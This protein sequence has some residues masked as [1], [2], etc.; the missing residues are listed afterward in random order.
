MMSRSRMV[1]A[2]TAFGE[3]P[4]EAAL[5]LYGLLVRRQPDAGCRPVA[6]LSP[7]DSAVLAGLRRDAE[8]HGYADVVAFLAPPRLTEEAA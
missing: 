2:A 4:P 3:A 6:G 1:E 7:E 8:R 5:I